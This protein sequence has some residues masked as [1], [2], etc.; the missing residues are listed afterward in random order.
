MSILYFFEAIRFPVQS[1]SIDRL[2]HPGGCPKVGGSR[3]PFFSQLVSKIRTDGAAEGPGADQVTD[4][5]DEEYG[6]DDRRR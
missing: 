1:E 6:S 4:D 3:P 5:G 2:S